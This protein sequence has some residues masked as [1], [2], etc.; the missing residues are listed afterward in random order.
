VFK[1]NSQRELM[2]LDDLPMSARNL[3]QKYRERRLYFRG[4]WRPIECTI[5]SRGCPYKCKFCGTWKIYNGKYRYRNPE[6]IA[7][8]LERIPE[9][10]VCFNDDNTLDH[11]KN[12]FMLAE[13][14][15]HRGIS[16]VYEVYGRAD[17]IVDHPELIEKWREI[18]MELLLVGLEACDNS[19]LGAMNKKTTIEINEKAIEICHSNGVEIASYLIVDPRFE[20]DDFRRLSD[21]V[22]RNNLSHPV[23]TILSPFPGTDFYYEVKKD[24]ITDSFEIYDFFHTVLQTTLPLDEFYEEFLNLYRTAYPTKKFIKAIFQRKAIL[25]PRMLT[26]NFKIRKRMTALRSHHDVMK[27]NPQMAISE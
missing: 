20:R 21:F 6:L 15:K 2:N 24:L 22:A 14:I 13:I 9:P 10:Y 1:I 11:T 23:F 7:D 12:A 8:E 19:T 25:S 5:S 17:T 27:Q 26:M 18:G 4:D 3:T 16:K